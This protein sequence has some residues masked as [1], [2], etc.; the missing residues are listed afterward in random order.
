MRP[1]NAMDNVQKAR[2]FHALV[3]TDIPAFLKYT[4]DSCLYIAN[5][6][7]AIIQSG[8]DHLLSPDFWIELSKTVHIN[9]E[10]Q[11]RRLEHSSVVFAEQLFGGYGAIFMIHTLLK[12][13]GTLGEADRKFKQAVDLFFS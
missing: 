3:L 1:L 13:A 2:L 8:K 9:I 7:D 5:H 10:K 4:T 11:G 6:T 12:Y